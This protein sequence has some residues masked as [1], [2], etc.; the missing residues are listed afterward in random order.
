ML[1]A[2]T[3]AAFMLALAACLTAMAAAEPVHQR[4]TFQVEPKSQ[5][6]IFAK[7]NAGDSVECKVMV[8]RGGKQDI[9]LRVENPYAATMFEQLLVSNVDSTTGE[10]LTSPIEKGYNFIAPVDGDYKFCTDNRMSRWTAKVVALF[11]TS[12]EH[13]DGV[14]SN[15]PPGDRPKELQDMQTTAERM[16][17]M[18]DELK[19]QQAHRHARDVAHRVT[20]ETSNSRTMWYSLLEILVVAGVCG[21]QIMLVRSWFPATRVRSA[22]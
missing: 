11:L 1:L 3:R 15:G 2:L 8:V 6:C 20:V 22:V 16:R 7:F 21:G 14:P 13:S 18:L 17:F 10:M 12:Q 4:L 9:R 19:E 5:Q